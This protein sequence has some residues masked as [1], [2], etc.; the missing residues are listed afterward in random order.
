MLLV[1]ADGQIS[2][3]ILK[4]FKVEVLSNTFV[5]HIQ[6]NKNNQFHIYILLRNYYIIL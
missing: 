6:K 5:C 2:V 4:Y 1:M 3:L